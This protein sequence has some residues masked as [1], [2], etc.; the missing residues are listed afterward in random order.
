MK[1][2]IIRLHVWKLR[3]SSRNR[4]ESYKIETA[5][6]RYFELGVT[7]QEIQPRI[8]LGGWKP[9]AVDLKAVRAKFDR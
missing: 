7:L 5:M 1:S 2:V 4:V 3:L 9:D 8:W 6:P